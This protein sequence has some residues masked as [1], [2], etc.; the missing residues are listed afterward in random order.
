MSQDAPSARERQLARELRLLRMTVGLTGKDVAARLG[1]S[2]SKVSR[3][4]TGR[5]GIGQDDLESLFGLYEAPDDKAEHLRRLAASARTQG[6]WDAYANSLSSGYSSLIKLEAGSAE[7]RCYCA[8]V[9]H[10]LLQT[11]EYS[12]HVIQST[13]QVPAPTEI[14]RRIDINRRRQ[15]VLRRENPPMRLSAVIDEAA[16]RR[17]IRTA[18][19]RID[20]SVTR[21]QFRRLAELST[22]PNVTIQVLRFKSGIPP[23]TAGSF[24]ILESMATNTPDVVYLEN[25][26]RF[27]FIDTEREVHQ[28]VQEFELLSSMA[29]DPDD[30]R[31]FV[32]RAAQR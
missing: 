26:T 16:F 3:I 22:W 11:P 9:P 30:S 21:A 20:N 27:F 28:Y 12:R 2:T 10:A 24:S 7:L 15:A 4:E 19:G 18:D 31:V 23:V 29:L 8:L 5:I 13:L 6:W 17:P 32:E 14:D 25:K 1:W